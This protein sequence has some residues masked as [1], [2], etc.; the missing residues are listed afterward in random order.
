MTTLLS[1]HEAIVWWEFQ[2]GKST[3]EIAE[4][5]R[6]SRSIPPYVRDL[7]E[8]DADVSQK[9][10]D[11]NVVFTTKGG[12][13][14]VGYVS[15]VLNRAREKIEK[16]L[17]DHA[18]SHR[19]DVESILDYKGLLIGFDYQANA[20]VYIVYT[21]KSGVIVWYRH[22]SYAGKLCPECPKESEC[23]DAL[24]AIMTEYGITLRSD[25][26]KLYMTQQS[27][28]IFSKLAAK[29]APRYRRRE[30]KESE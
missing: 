10:N 22:D 11:L 23:R 29:E 18:N 17:R 9:Q 27:I 20:Q 8:K 28:A 2:H 24:D 5:Y 4:D 15:R 12:E 19:L 3:S 1:N 6:S 14:A 7:L 26:E 25:E 21:M 16:T 30:D 13:P